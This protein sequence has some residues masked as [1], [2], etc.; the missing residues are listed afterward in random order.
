M[1]LESDLFFGNM[2]ME[3]VFLVWVDQF[4]FGKTEK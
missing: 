3:E 2:V 4:R 1:G